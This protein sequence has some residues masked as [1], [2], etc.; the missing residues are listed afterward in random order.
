M[1]SLV[2]L[3]KK[4]EAEEWSGEVLVTSVEGNATLVIK[5]GKLL[6]AHRPIDRALERLERIS[7]VEAP[8]SSVV[9][10]CKDWQEFVSATISANE[11]NY[12][13]IVEYLKRDRLELF[14]RIFF[15]TNVEV[16]P[17]A[18]SVELADMPELHFYDPRGLDRLVREAL[19]RQEEWPGIQRRL[20]SGKRVFIVNSKNESLDEPSSELDEIDLVLKD[21][22]SKHRASSSSVPFSGSSE[23]AELLKLC[24]GRN[25]V[26]DIVR[27]SEEGEFLTLKRILRLWEQGSILPKEE[28]SAMISSQAQNSKQIAKEAKAVSFWGFILLLALGLNY[29][30]SARYQAEPFSQHNLES[31]LEVYRGLSGRYPLT[32]NELDQ[33]G[34]GAWSSPQIHYTFIGSS[35]YRLEL[36]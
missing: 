29:L 14:Y 31:A 36:K 28:D 17:R 1:K 5:S 2:D 32:L 12:E 30:S 34:L 22:E 13:R 8:P 9:L 10:N 27:L 6:F 3:F 15:W 7:W 20:G 35:E 18:Y 16:V 4:L 24:N 33:A 26:Q 11:K 21:F 19:S 25:T 23:D